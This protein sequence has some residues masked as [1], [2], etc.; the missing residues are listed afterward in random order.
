MS[1]VC[2]VGAGLSGLTV[3]HRLTKRG[4][5]VTVLERSGRP[6]GV[7]RSTRTGS[8]LA[9]SGPNSVMA[10][11]EALRR[12]V[13]ELGLDGERVTTDP[14]S[15][16]R[17]V[18]RDGRLH[19]I[20]MSPPTLLRSKLLSTAGK[21]RVL[22]EPFVRRAPEDANESVGAF[23]RRRLGPELLDYGINPFVAGVFAGDPDLLELRSAFP[24]MHA[25]EARSGSLIRGQ[26]ALARMRRKSGT[27][28]P[29][30]DMFAFR[31]GMQTLTDALARS[32]DVTT[33]VDIG[34]IV[35]TGGGY[36]VAGTGPDGP[37][38]IDARAVVVAT[39]ADA[40]RHLLRAL[41]PEVDAPLREIPYPPVTI[42]VSEY[43]RQ[44]VAH[45]LDG[46]GF[47]VPA[48]EHR[49]ILGT[50]FSS[51]LFPHRAP[52][53]NVLL[54]TFVGGMRQPAE[55]RRPDD[56]VRALVAD[57]LSDLIGARSPVT[58]TITR[59]ERAIPQYTL[60]HAARMAQIDGVETRNPG[61]VLA[62]NY[63]G[64]ISVGD[65]VTSGEATAEGVLA[66]LA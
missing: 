51:S 1:D 2:V 12:L 8:A 46:F 6:G 19:P 45:A 27:A 64:G 41:A 23:V 47:L 61:L 25:L 26:I 62:A 36:R 66:H 20:P 52:D 32:V 5:S 29:P 43:R 38:A 31:D 58:Q 16:R 10:S 54:T 50:V 55:A 60:G 21:L 7:I 56:E 14:S 15:S 24:R 17:Y 48:R 59:H 9:E 35:R 42:V 39:D 44:D 33:G 30:S 18:V 3:A 22:R 53:G 4:L 34:E 13:S 49:R 57:E 65:C 11:A 63:R 28:K 40:A 37:L